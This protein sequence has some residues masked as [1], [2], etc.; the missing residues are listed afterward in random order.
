MTA[1]LLNEAE[2]VSSQDKRMVYTGPE[3]CDNPHSDDVKDT[4]PDG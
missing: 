4:Y 1:T 2:E 3:F